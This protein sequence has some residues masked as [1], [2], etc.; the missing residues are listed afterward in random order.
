LSVSV[1]AG[2][3]LLGEAESTVSTEVSCTTEMGKEN[4]ETTTVSSTFTVKD[5]DPGVEVVV[6]VS[7]TQ[8]KGKVPYKYKYQDTRVDT[9]VLPVDTGVD[10]IFEGVQVVNIEWKASDPSGKKMTV[11]A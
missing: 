5:V 10:G 11:E 3:P 4:G 7:G 2:V 6:R 9:L 8:A 1:T